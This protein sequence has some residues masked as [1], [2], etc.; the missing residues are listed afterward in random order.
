MRKH[1]VISSE[2]YFCGF[3]LQTIE[4]SLEW[5]GGGLRLLI[6]TQQWSCWV[7]DMEKR[8]NQQWEHHNIVTGGWLDGRFLVEFGLCLGECKKQWERERNENWNWI[9]QKLFS[10]EIELKFVI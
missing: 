10:S 6:D 8:E 9:E 7:D 5:A 4:F 1:Q 3:D 2:T